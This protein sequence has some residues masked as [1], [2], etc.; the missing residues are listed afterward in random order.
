MKSRFGFH[1]KDSKINTHVHVI[2]HFTKESIAF[3][4]FFRTQSSDIV[5]VFILDLRLTNGNK[6]LLHKNEMSFTLRTS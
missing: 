2:M 1:T 5:C 6:I 4:M 3:F